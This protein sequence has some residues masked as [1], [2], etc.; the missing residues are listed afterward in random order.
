MPFGGCADIVLAFV[1]FIFTPVFDP[2]QAA[3]GRCA[4]RRL[5]SFYSLLSLTVLKMPLA[6]G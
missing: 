3:A 6:A 2:I 5:P 1:F 4:A